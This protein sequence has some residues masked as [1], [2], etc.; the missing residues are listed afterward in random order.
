[1]R[2]VGTYDVRGS[3]SCA[4]VTHVKQPLPC[5]QRAIPLHAGLSGASPGSGV[6]RRKL[7]ARGVER[8]PLWINMMC[9]RSD[10]LRTHG[11]AD[12]LGRGI[13]RRAFQI[14]PGAA[15]GETLRPQH[16]G[17]SVKRVVMEPIS[18]DTDATSFRHH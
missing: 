15:H 11:K 13:I 4:F 17:N 14:V 18:V 16:G 6:L 9:H 3:Y 2:L 10:A 5:K 8:T 12:P 7:S 1:M